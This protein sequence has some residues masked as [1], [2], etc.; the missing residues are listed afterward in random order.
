MDPT[1]LNIIKILRGNSRT[2]F[3]AI[4]EKLDLAESTI[5]KRVGNTF[6]FK[7]NNR[8]TAVKYILKELFEKEESYLSKMLQKIIDDIA[9]DALSVY[10]F[11]SMAEGKQRAGSDLDLFFVVKDYKSKLK[12]EKK[13]I[14]NHTESVLETGKKVSSIIVTL[15]EYIKMK[16]K[17]K[18]LLMNVGMGRHLKGKKLNEL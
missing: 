5:R 16:T 4:A 14:E 8:N 9:P 7:I 17:N 10:L 11:G 15:T 12:A 18:Q 3:S 13:D 2:P 1:D 6:S